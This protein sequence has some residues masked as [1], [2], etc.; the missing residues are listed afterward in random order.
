MK[1]EEADI[2]ELDPLPFQLKTTGLEQSM[3]PRQTIPPESGTVPEQERK[4]QESVQAPVPVPAPSGAPQELR[5]SERST[6]GK[7]PS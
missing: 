2:V 5:R 3:M 1:V 7:L 6:R 4:S